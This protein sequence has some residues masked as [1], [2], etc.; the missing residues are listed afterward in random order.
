MNDAQILQAMRKYG[1][2]FASALAMAGFVADDVNL[3]RIKAA[4]PDL[5]EKYNE[6]A[7]LEA[8]KAPPGDLQG[9]DADDVKDET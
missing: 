4:F 9:S 3:A 7:A 2:G 8:A 5:W 6:F 1:G